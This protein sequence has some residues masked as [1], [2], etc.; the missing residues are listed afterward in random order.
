MKDENGFFAGVVI[1]FLC[2]AMKTKNV[3]SK[4]KTNIFEHLIWNKI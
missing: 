2:S 4:K 3:N 1:Y